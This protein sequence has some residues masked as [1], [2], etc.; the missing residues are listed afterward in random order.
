[1]PNAS[2][3]ELRI[4][5]ESLTPL[6]VVVKTVTNVDNILRGKNSYESL[7][8]IRFEE[9]LGRDRVS[10]D[11]DLLV[12]NI[13]GKVVLVTGAGGSIG[14]ELCRQ[15]IANAP[16]KLILF[17]QSEIAL[18]KIKQNYKVNGAI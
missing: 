14:S 9:L 3:E 18:Y 1:M 12:G 15:I 4:I 2:R 6:P 17:E 8:E 13:Y 5:I 7:E 16:A 11:K 10:P